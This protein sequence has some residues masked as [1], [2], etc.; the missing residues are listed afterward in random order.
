[1]SQL[2]PEHI[3]LSIKRALEG[4][5]NLSQSQLAVRGFSTPTIRRLFSNLCNI[6]G[7]YLEVGLYCGGTFV[8]SFNH[9]LIS[10][11]I[12]DYSQDFSVNTVKEE[13]QINVVTHGDKAKSVQV[14]DVNCFSLDKSVLPENID[15]FFYDGN[16]AEEFQANALP[17]F[18]DKLANKFIYICDDFNWKEPF[19]GTNRALE[20][21]KD[22]VEIEYVQVLRGYYLQ[23]DPIWHN[24]VAIYLINKK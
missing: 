24:G 11:G 18:I 12:E 22:K 8:S 1:M 4:Q 21:L 6:E 19:E 5:S 3:N 7:T 16:H 9:N 10:I 23:D 2:T 14:I 15:I 17:H 13:L 20:S